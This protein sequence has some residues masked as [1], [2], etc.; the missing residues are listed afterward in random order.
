MFVC[1]FVYRLELYKCSYIWIRVR[2]RCECQWIDNVPF[3]IRKCAV[4][5]KI[6]FK[7]VLFKWNMESFYSYV[8]KA[9]VW[10]L[11]YIRRSTKN[12]INDHCHRFYNLLRNIFFFF[13]LSITNCVVL[14]VAQAG[15]FEFLYSA[16]AQISIDLHWSSLIS[17]DPNY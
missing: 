11:F 5:A 2:L 4:V 6:F 1:T 8:E 16:F 9:T 15:L 3:S 13:N 12:I 17:N 10:F 14:I 7:N